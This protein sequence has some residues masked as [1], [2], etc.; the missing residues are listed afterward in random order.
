MTNVIKSRQIYF[1]KS[2]SILFN[3]CTVAWKLVVLFK[4]FN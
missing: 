3:D 1:E 4:P 2:G